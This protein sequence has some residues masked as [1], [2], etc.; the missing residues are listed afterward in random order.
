MHHEAGS[1]DKANHTK[2]EIYDFDLTINAEWC[3]E[4]Q[5]EK[6]EETI[7]ECYGWNRGFYAIVRTTAHLKDTGWK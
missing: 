3:K 5:I 2:G 4:W 7:E 6:L 1:K